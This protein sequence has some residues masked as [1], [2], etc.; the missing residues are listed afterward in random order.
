MQTFDR[1]RPTG[2]RVK[3]YQRT[4]AV[5]AESLKHGDRA[6]LRMV[7]ELR[8]VIIIQVAPAKFNARR[9]DAAFTEHLR[10]RI[11]GFEVIRMQIEVDSRHSQKMRR[12][13]RVHV[14]APWRQVVRARPEGKF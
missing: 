3:E 11:G 7:Q 6:L 9:T 12:G 10:Q 13:P 14:R 1:T 4:D 2:I 8:G 5:A